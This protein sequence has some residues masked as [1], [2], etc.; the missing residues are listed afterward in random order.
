ME[1]EDYNKF[2]NWS[3]YINNNDIVKKMYNEI[4]D[5]YAKDK[6]LLLNEDYPK[7]WCSLDKNNKKK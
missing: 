4:N 7:Y 1:L 6:L 2:V 3:D 5:S